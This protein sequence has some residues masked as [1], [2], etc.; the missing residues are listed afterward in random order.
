MQIRRT[1]R[2]DASQNKILIYGLKANTKKNETSK[3]KRA[4]ANSNSNF[5]VSFY[6]KCA[7]WP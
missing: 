5:N 3:A 7:L 6:D 2:E 4:Q 1:Q